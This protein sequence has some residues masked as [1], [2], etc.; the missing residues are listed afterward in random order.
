M[1]QLCTWRIPASVLKFRAE[2]NSGM[3]KLQNFCA[4]LI[5]TFFF[6]GRSPKAPGTCGSLAALPFAWYL[7][8]LPVNGAWGIIAG[9]FLAGS[10]AASR[11]IARTGVADH[12]SIVIDEVIGIFLVTSVAAHLWWHYALAFSLFRIFDIWKPWPVR[13]VD[14]NWKTGVGAI[15]DDMIAA[16]MAAGILYVVLRY[17]AGA[18]GSAA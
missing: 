12:Q 7:W 10:W 3:A 17:T 18:V 16:L 13:W 4:E 9:T 8:Q 5:A 11:V 1:V 2:G 6:V 14:R 15:L